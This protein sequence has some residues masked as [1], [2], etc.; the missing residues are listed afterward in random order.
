MPTLDLLLVWKTN[1]GASR[2]DK[3][4]MQSE[5]DIHEYDGGI[6]RC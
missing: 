1:S 3:A 5:I 4:M 2:Q 6:G